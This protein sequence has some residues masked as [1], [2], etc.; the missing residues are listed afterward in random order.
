M[1]LIVT[2]DVYSGRPNPQWTLAPAES[3]EFQRRL[4]ALHPLAGDAA[5]P[6]APLGYRGLEVQGGPAPV[7]VFRGR[8][9]VGGQDF[10]DPRRELERWLI[11]SGRGSVDPALIS[12]IDSET[13]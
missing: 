3:T 12:Y 4:A 1:A 8:V 11:D 10:A 6:A 9:T 13:A 7:R 2:L 5:E